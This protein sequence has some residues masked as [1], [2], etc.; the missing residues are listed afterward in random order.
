MTAPDI[1]RW[2]T[3]LPKRINDLNDA[4]QAPVA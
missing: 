2:T 1:E 4:K 3:L